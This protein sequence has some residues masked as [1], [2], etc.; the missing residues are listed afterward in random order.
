M[1]LLLAACAHPPLVDAVEEQLAEEVLGRGQTP[2]RIFV[3]L[4]SLMAEGCG[5]PDI[6]TYT[7]VGGG[8]RALGVTTAIKTVLDSGDIQWTFENAGLDDVGAGELVLKTTSDHASFEVTYIL[9]T[10]GITV[11]GTVPVLLC[12]VA[13]SDPSEDGI[14]LQGDVATGGSLEFTEDA[15]GTK[16]LAEGDKPFEGLHFNPPTDTTPW[17]GW[18]K[19]S[20]DS[21]DATRGQALEL[22]G[23][24]FIDTDLWPGTA[25]GIASN[26]VEWDRVVD[27]RLP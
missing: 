7:F 8:A 20:D 13:D 15:V 21:E 12:D 14:A 24:A 4:S 6:E 11:T 26:G 9:E 16:V 17:A 19:W 27:V 25:S 1:I 10:A 23:A 2:I 22:D 3:A 5:V 18:A